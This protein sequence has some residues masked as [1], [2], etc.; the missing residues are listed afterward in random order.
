MVTETSWEK[1]YQNRQN[2]IHSWSNE[3]N[4]KLQKIGSDAV[5]VSFL[6]DAAD[7]SKLADLASR[8]RKVYVISEHTIQNQWHNVTVCNLPI[9][10]YGAYHIPNIEIDGTITRSFNCFL[11]RTDPIRQSWFYLLY[12]R[13]LL[14]QAYVSFNMRQRKGLWYPSES[15]HETFE[16]YHDNYLSSFS[17][18]K[19]QIKK[20][21]PYKN[22]VDNDN[23]REII[24]ST[25]FSIVVETY[26]ERT[27]CQVF[28]EKTW[29]VIQLPRPWLLFAATGCVKK[30]RDMGFDV[31]DDYVDHSYDSFDTSQ[32]CVDRQEAI[33]SETA[34]L[35][36]LVVTESVL[37][38]WKQKAL[39]NR[40]IMKQWADS[41]ETKCR[42]QFS[43]ILK[44]ET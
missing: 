24:L 31:F 1:H 10:F 3:F 4:Q 44:L 11:N 20:I 25:K 32:T 7:L 29:R 14:D 19:D 33:L 22:F 18:I 13:N 12:A 30:L 16:Y 36:E 6:V 34:R 15:H 37:T 23:L 21:V 35:K 26:F 42:F 40:N 38:D 5:I 28:S 39:H 2:T 43:E 8:S 27:D 41:W 17:D 9:D